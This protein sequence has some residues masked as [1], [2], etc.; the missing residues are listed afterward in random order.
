MTKSPDC[1]LTERDLEMFQARTLSE[2]LELAWQWKQMPICEDRF[3]IGDQIL[4]MLVQ[5][6]LLAMWADS[7]LENPTSSFDS[8]KPVEHQL[9]F[10]QK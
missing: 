10:L 9:Y 1:G 5:A 4:E 3:E 8:P 7:T 2:A 6:Y